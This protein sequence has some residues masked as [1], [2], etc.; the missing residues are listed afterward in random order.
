M[1]GRTEGATALD[2]PAVSA[3]LGGT[4][5]VSADVDSTADYSGIQVLVVMPDDAGEID[6]L[7]IATT[8]ASGQFALTLRAPD[9]GIYPLLIRRRGQT[10][11]QTDL[12]IADG[13]ST[14][15]SAEL[16]IRSRRGVRL[17]SQ[18]NAAYDAYRNV[19]AQHAAT[20]RGLLPGRDIDALSTAQ[21]Q[22]ATVLWSLREN[23]GG[24]L[25]AELAAVEAV[26]L[27]A[28][29]D[30][31][32][33]VAYASEVEPGGAAYVPTTRV[34]RKAI[35]L[36]A[37]VDS[38]AAFLGRRRDAASEPIEAA[39]V[40]AELVQ[41]YL[42]A[43]R[44]D[45]ALA[46]AR[47][48]A[49]DYPDTPFAEWAERAEYEAEY[50]LAGLPAPA[51]TAESPD[52]P[53]TLADFRGRHV[54]LEFYEPGPGY[55]T[56]LP[57]LTALTDGAGRPTR[58]R[59][60]LDRRCRPRRSVRR[61]PHAARPPHLRRLAGRRASVALQR[62]RRPDALPDRA[63]RHHRAE[64]RRVHAARAPAHRA[65]PPPGRTRLVML[66]S[67]YASPHARRRKLEDEH[68]P[69]R[70]GGPRPCRRRC[71]G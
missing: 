43:Q 39:A 54:I 71:R 65:G 21:Q 2:A 31:R 29:V 41:T 35:G 46:A 32:R 7:G 30:D 24:T 19:R 51:F 5:T 37:G 20:A 13:D 68:A 57:T 8:D 42:E 17:R 70:C 33:A 15:L 67:P 55:A 4:I 63:G 66:F 59:V 12:V 26:A 18:E 56:V 44:R 23:Y 14:T 1:W 9:R 38:A 52:G 64:V 27:L 50:L 62:Q 49:A 11:A 60:R 6:T 36:T 28:G 61:K 69:R 3:W 40:Q 48:L 10:F 25:G 45:D 58:A 47:A 16:P 53:I 22:A 34:A